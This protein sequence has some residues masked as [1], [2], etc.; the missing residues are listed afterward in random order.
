MKIRIHRHATFQITNWILLSFDLL[1]NYEIYCQNLLRQK[2]NR[3]KNIYNDHCLNLSFNV[4]KKFYR[5]C[6]NKRQLCYVNNHTIEIV[7]KNFRMLLFLKHFKIF[8]IV[9]CNRFFCFENYIRVVDFF[10]FVIFSLVMKK[11]KK[12]NEMCDLYKR[13]SALWFLFSKF[14]SHET[15][16]CKFRFMRYVLKS[17]FVFIYHI[18]HHE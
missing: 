12:K 1:S 4:T 13:Q 6:T 10:I 7:K 16:I 2:L 18:H 14:Y 8:F 9:K 15:I 11:K 5:C 17:T 3:V